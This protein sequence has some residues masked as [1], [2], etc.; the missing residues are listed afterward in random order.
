VRIGIAGSWKERD[1]ESWGLRFDLKSFKDARYQLGS[2][3][4]QTGAA[5]TVGSDSRFTAD[6]YA[7][8]AIFPPTRMRSR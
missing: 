8:E 5:I 2:A 3:I 4:A 7:V 1:R 6:K